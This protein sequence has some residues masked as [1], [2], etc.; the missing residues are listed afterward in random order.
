MSFLDRTII[1]TRITPLPDDADVVVKNDLLPAEDIDN[2]FISLKVN[3]LERSLNLGDLPSPST[4]RTN[5]GLGVLA[6]GN[7]ASNVPFERNSTFLQG[8]AQP[9]ANYNP[10]ENLDLSVAHTQRALDVLV[11]DKLKRNANLAD[12]PSALIAR[13]NLGLGSL[14]VQSSAAGVPFDPAGLPPIV[15]STDVQSALAVVASNYVTL[16]LEET[17]TGSK[18]F[19]APLTV[20]A[21]AQFLGDSVTFNAEVT[22][23]QDVVFE[24]DVDF[25]SSNVTAVTQPIGTSN[26]TI[27]TTE[28]A[29]N[30]FPAGIICMWSG[31]I[32]AIPQGWALCNGAN[33]TPDLRDRFVIGAGSSYSVDSTGGSKDAVVVSHSHPFSTTT[34]N[35]GVHNH[36]FSGSTGSAGSHSHSG[37]T[38]GVGNH[39]HPYVEPRSVTVQR[40]TRNIGNFSGISRAGASTG[41]AGA[42]SHSLNINSAGSHNHSFSGTT[43]NA[44]SH[45]HSL[46]GTTDTVGESGIDKNLPPY[47][48]LAYIMKL[49]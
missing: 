10:F 46:S 11:L 29:Q 22:F 12:L 26:K 44:G 48:A 27:A 19:T 5:L 23:E 8:S 7:A 43:N 1:T 34:E 13:S 30:A 3:K 40:G 32:N 16:S 45:N 36:G 42:H 38:S 17:I 37:S 49:P 2:N 33:N 4:A 25:Q 24:D 20:T 21:I 6:T 28:F 18:T 31:A 39:S 9:V 35:A 14:A 15:T 47:Y 41:G